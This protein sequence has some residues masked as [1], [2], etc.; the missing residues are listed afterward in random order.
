MSLEATVI[1]VDNSEW[2][3]NGDYAPTRF[4]AQRD[5]VNIIANSKIGAHPESVV[6]LMTLAGSSP[7]MLAIP[8]NEHGNILNGLHRASLGGEIHFEGALQVAHLALKHRANKNQR[9]RIIVFVGSP[10][11]DDQKS[12]VRLG[13][14]LKKNN[15]A[16]DVISLGE[17]EV[18]DAKLQAF[19]E[20]VN[21]GDTGTLLSVKPGSYL[22]S[23]SLRQ[24]S[25]LGGSS[26][27]HTGGDMDNDEFE[28]GVD[29]SLDPELAMALRM[30]LAE[31]QNRQNAA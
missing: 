26:S 30:S 16:V 27:A 3:R 29:P 2:A 23:D 15:I 13:R 6:G 21:S 19:I 31:E 25:I 28:F 22:L 7:E 18:N 14:R 12:L 4:G 10:I 1:L 24:S 20:A 11:N 9:Q 17:V 8:T 5:C